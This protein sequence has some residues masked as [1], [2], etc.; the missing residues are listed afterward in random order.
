MKFSRSY[1]KTIN[2]H[3]WII[4]H[5]TLCFVWWLFWD[6]ITATKMAEN[7]LSLKNFVK[8]WCWIRIIVWISYKSTLWMYSLVMCLGYSVWRSYSLNFIIK[9]VN[10]LLHQFVT[11]DGWYFSRFLHFIPLRIHSLNRWKVFS[12]STLPKM[13]IDK[14]DRPFCLAAPK[15][16]L[17]FIQ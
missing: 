2:L 10:R 16:H 9:K 7:G 4:F 1:Y 17:H 11:F 8:K 6:S 12:E 14:G 3:F 5:G 13:M 15:L